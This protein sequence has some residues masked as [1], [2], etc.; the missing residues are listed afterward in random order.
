MAL[1]FHF[2]VSFLSF[3]SLSDIERIDWNDALADETNQIDLIQRPNLIV[4][5]DI[6]FDNSLFPGLCRTIDRLFNHAENGCKMIL[7]NA[8]RNANT[9]SEFFSE[10]SNENFSLMIKAYFFFIDFLLSIYSQIFMDFVF[11]NW[12]Q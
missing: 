9:Q 8:I 10:L 4:A 2:S 12:S 11:A 1:V 3:L 6:I 7:M 5:A